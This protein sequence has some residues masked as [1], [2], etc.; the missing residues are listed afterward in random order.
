MVILGD[1]FTINE[2]HHLKIS[3][4][5]LN[6]FCPDMLKYGDNTFYKPYLI[7]EL[8]L[9]T[10]YYLYEE[11]LNLFYGEACMP[12]GEKA[13][14]NILEDM[15]KDEYFTKLFSIKIHDD[16]IIAERKYDLNIRHYPKENNVYEFL[17]LFVREFEINFKTFLYK[18]YYYAAIGKK[19]GKT[20]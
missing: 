3:E 14:R 10:V 18:L 15:C 8:P 7:N 5:K 11:K 16:I 6:C 9:L 2:H 13:D 17:E 4:Q 12:I 19:I 1:G 20:T